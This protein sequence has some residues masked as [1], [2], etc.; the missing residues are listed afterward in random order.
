MNNLIKN[1]SK[2]KLAPEMVSV[3]AKAIKDP[4]YPKLG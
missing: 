2:K 3:I 4:L 1:E